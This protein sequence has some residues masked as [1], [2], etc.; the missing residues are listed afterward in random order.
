MY[1]H[2]PQLTEQI[3][4]VD[5]LLYN[6]T[7]SHETLLVPDN[8][9]ELFIPLGKDLEIQII[10]ST[11]S[12][13]MRQGQG[14][15]LSPRRR[16]LEVLNSSNFLLI[17]VNP[18]YSRSFSKG[19]IEISSSVFEFPMDRDMLDELMNAAANEDIYQASECLEGLLGDYE[20]AFNYN[21]TILESID[22]IRHT[23]GTISVKEIY[24]SLNV[25]KS[26]LE[27]HFNREIGLTPKE[28][29]KIEKINSFID[30]YKNSKDQSL[31]KLTYLCGYYD[32]S[33]LIKDFRYFLNTSPKRY[34]SAIG[35]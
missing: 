23:S 3:A 17:K 12:I 25:S 27:Q 2:D 30:T 24:S 4:I 16:G 29:C 34:F 7:T 20:E 19:L 22:R 11:R 13:V 14:Y 32:Q 31:T 6:S 5:K 28:F 1:T 15:F 9:A 8:Y 10:G 35:I 18:I 33:H 21:L 26:K